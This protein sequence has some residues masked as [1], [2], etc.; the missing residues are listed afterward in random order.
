MKM[1]QRR[2]LHN[3]RNPTPSMYHQLVTVEVEFSFPVNEYS[4]EE[5][6]IEGTSECPGRVRLPA[7]EE[8]G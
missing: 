1:F 3:S 6:C 8:C 5:R 4:G 2:D 7:A